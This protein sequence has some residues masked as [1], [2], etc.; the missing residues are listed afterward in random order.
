MNNA[1]LIDELFD[2]IGHLNKIN[3]KLWRLLAL[4][5]SAAEYEALLQELGGTPEQEGIKE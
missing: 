5:T 3:G 2:T 1:A 4:H